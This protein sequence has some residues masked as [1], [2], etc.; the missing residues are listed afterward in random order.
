M[1]FNRAQVIDENF[2]AFLSNRRSLPARPLPDRR[3]AIVHPDA[4]LEM[5]ESQMITR[6][7]DLIARELRAGDIGFYT[8]ASAGHEGNAAVGRATRHTDPAFLHYRSGAFVAER[9]RKL[10]GID[11][12]YDTLLSQMASREDP[13]AGGRHKVWGSRP[14]W[15]LPQTSTIASHLP[16]A[17]GTALAIVRARRL[18]IDL[19]IPEDSIAVCSFG[20]ASCNHS[21]AAGAFNAAC[22]GSYQAVPMPILFVCEDN[23]YGISVRTPEG[24]I[25]SNFRDHPGLT[26]LQADGLDLLDTHAAATKAVDYCRS[27]RA[28][29]FLHLKLVRMLGH[30]GS[31]MEAAYRSLDEIEATEAR[32]PLLRSAQAILDLG[33]KTAGEILEQYEAIR[34]KTRAAADRAAGRPRL[35]SAAEVMRP[36]APHSPDPVRAEAVR[37]DYRDRRLEVFESEARLPEKAQ[38]RHLAVHINHALFDLMAKYPEA[39]VFGEDVAAKGGVYHVT[40]GL[41]KRFKYGRVFNT[42]LDE[43]TILGL[44]QG[45]GYMGLLPIPEIQYL[46]YFHNACDQIRGEAC[47]MQFFS[48]DQFRNPM[49]VR[50]ASLAYQKGFG[51]HF[52]ND[53]SIAALRDIPGLILACPSRGDDAAGMLRTAAALAHIDGRIV[54]FL[55]PIALYMTKDLH[56]K[57]DGRWLF[58]YPPPEVAV[59]FLQPRVYDPD[60]VDLAIVTFGNGVYLSLRAGETLRKECGAGTRVIDLRWLNPLNHEAIARHA[61]ECGRLLVVDEGRRT[62]GLSE[63]VFTSIVE[64]CKTR[65]VL[66]RVTGEDSFIPLGPAADHVLPTEARILEAA[67]EV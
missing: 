46:A 49:I 55:E 58:S 25:E 18:G 65:P 48:K 52:H 28:P 3:S 45:A 42:P 43:Q 38:P 2:I 8:I 56:E 50:V 53:N 19:P 31:D 24:W 16:K 11:I 30:A 10:P 22:W 12:V 13:A 51:G 41:A 26:Y 39:I 66:R 5:F 63:A 59:P 17:V 20:D 36:L 62:G 14:L 47:S 61:D 15:I 64:H 35:S 33:L 9:A 6:H 57:G 23:G 7:L 4:L 1:R 29:V 44:A 32:D 27:R 37:D 21:T 34:D 40:A 60:A 54:I 67:R